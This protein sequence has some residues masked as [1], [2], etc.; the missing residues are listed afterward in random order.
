MWSKNLDGIQIWL[1]VK[2]HLDNLITS[3]RVIVVHEESP[4]HQPST[5][6]D[7][8]PL[9]VERIGIDISAQLE[10][11]VTGVLPFLEQD[12]TGQLSVEGVQIVGIGLIGEIPVVVQTHGSDSVV[13]ALVH[14]LAIL[15]QCIDH[16]GGEL[17]ES[18]L[19]NRMFFT[20]T[21]VMVLGKVFQDAD[22]SVAFSVVVHHL[23]DFR[24][25][26]YRHNGV[27]LGL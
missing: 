27:H 21:Y 13:S 9:G 3:F 24:N 16:V 2:K 12:L 14:E 17:K 5:L 25:F 19:A 23:F 7:E 26:E 8:F 20:K 18:K 6:S 11:I 15:E 10:K 1:L 22:V 4:V